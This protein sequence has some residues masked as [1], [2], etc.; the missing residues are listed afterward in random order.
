MATLRELLKLKGSTP[1][2]YLLD[3]ENYIRIGFRPTT[4]GTGERS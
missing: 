3:Q 2:L 1:G 4:G